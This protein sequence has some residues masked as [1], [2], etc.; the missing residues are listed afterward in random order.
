MGECKEDGMEKTD[1]HSVA[2]QD[3]S[4]KMEGST[5]DATENGNPESD[6]FMCL[7][8]RGGWIS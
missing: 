4:E 1:W 3:E 6:W 7:H 5:Q 2:N 8:V